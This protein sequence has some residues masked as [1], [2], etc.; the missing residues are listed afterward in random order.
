[1][2]AEVIRDICLTANGTLPPR[3]SKPLRQAG[4]QQLNI[5]PDTLNEAKHARI[6]RRGALSEALDGLESAL[7]AGFTLAKINT[8]RSAVWRR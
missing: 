6:T 2:A 5:S 1:M 7:G 4:V 8:V 3:L